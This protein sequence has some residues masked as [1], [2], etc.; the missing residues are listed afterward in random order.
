MDQLS[1][2]PSRRLAIGA[3]FGA[4]FCGAC[5]RGHENNAPV[6]RF[7]R[8]PQAEINGRSR[9]DIIEGTVKGALPGQQLVLYARS[10]RWWVQP[11]VNQ[12]FT[13]LEKKTFKWTNAT[14][15]GTEY[16][17]LLVE[18]G[19]QP[20]AVLDKLPG[21]SAQIAAVASALGA[22]KPP[23]PGLRFGGY[24][25]RARDVPSPRGGTL[26]YYDPG[27]A[28]VDGAGAL[29]LR[30][31][32]TEKGW[33][34][35]EICLTTSLGYGTYEYTIRDTGRLD[36]AAVFGMFTYDYAGGALNNREMDIEISHWGDPSSKNGQYIVQP[37]YVAA[38]VERFNVPAG[39]LIH[40]LT[41]QEGRA[42]FRTVRG[43]SDGSRGG[44]VAERTFTSGIP[45]PG[46][47]SAR[48]SLY[49]FSQGYVQLKD[50]AEVVVEQFTYLP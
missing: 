22:A 36:S 2:L 30:I 24:E 47:E 17:A 26:N 32:K 44:V 21:V 48:L 7:S 31:A 28:W 11:L 34:C 45:T 35:A 13:V 49:S 50:P 4:A 33:T 43:S 18:P 46:I 1:E 40:S 39:K 8:I 41:W 19:F 5:R 23:S 27:N 12:P 16:A 20:P 6:I 14:H 42:T 25:W 10:G 3:I 38:N 9:N 37:Y 15:L 29:H